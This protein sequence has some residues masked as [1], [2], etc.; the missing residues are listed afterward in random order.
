MLWCAEVK[1]SDIAYRH[2]ALLKTSAILSVFS[3]ILQS[4]LLTIKSKGIKKAPAR[5]GAYNYNQ[6]PIRNI[7]MPC[8]LHGL[9]C[10]YT[11][12]QHFQAVRKK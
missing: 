1:N 10:A 6:V 11:K 8:Y 4:N 5:A 2:A 12:L 3:R 7:V 9:S